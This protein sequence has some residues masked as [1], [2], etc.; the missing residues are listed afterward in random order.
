MDPIDQIRFSVHDS[1]NNVEVGPKHVS[2][3]L[4]GE[5]QRDVTDFL[6]GTTRDVDPL[7]VQISIETGSLVFVASGLLSATT[8]W[9]DL[10]HIT[11][12]DALT[13]IDSKRANVLERWQAAAREKPN[14]SYTLADKAG[15]ALFVVDARST[16]T[17]VDDVWVQVEKYL[18]GKIIDMGGKTKANVHLE[19]ENGQAV[20]VS[21]S[22][23]VL[24]QDER[25][26]LYRPALLHVAAEENLHTGEL[27]NLR[28]LAFET[29]QPSYDDEEFRLMVERGTKAWED[30]V[31][32]TEW[33]AELRGGQT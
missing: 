30:V 13:L 8:L 32:A 33:T 26:R 1:I 9:A 31:S 29:H 15:Q 16:L 3:A 11:S 24:A 6:K 22:H 20:T 28:L 5:F 12:P 7:Q 10:T 25:N 17:K 18:H 21:S 4:L 19:L 14:R 27:R 2:L 23:E